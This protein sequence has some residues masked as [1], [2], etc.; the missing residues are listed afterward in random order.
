MNIKEFKG[1]TPP[2]YVDSLI[3]VFPIVLD[4]S[5][6]NND[7]S[8]GDEIEMQTN[9]DGEEV[10]TAEVE[11]E[12]EGDEGDDEMEEEPYEPLKGTVYIPSAKKNQKLNIRPQNVQQVISL[13]FSKR[14]Q[15]TEYEEMMNG[16]M[17]EE[18]YDTGYT[19]RRRSEKKARKRE[20]L[21]FEK[22]TAKLNLARNDAR[23]LE[24]ADY[25]LAN[26]GSVRVEEYSDDEE[27]EADM[28]DDLTQ[29]NKESHVVLK[30]G[31]VPNSETCNKESECSKSDND[32]NAIQPSSSD[33]VTDKPSATLPTPTS[34]AISL[35]YTFDSSSLSSFPSLLATP[36]PASSV[37][38]SFPSPFP[39]FSAA[40]P[41]GSFSFGTPN[42]N[43][44]NLPP[45]LSSEK[46]QESD[47]TE[48]TTSTIVNSDIFGNSASAPVDIG[49]IFGNSNAKLFD[50]SKIET[51]N[52]S[53]GN[54][55]LFSAE[56]TYGEEKSESKK[57]EETRDTEKVIFPI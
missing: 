1:D 38:S 45:L 29:A 31:G 41:F 21:N 33:K 55:S 51:P 39:S 57:D 18:Y 16:K 47:T 20:N 3:K 9:S 43:S 5:N 6:I 24:H 30:E 32:A 23:L 27:S 28:V 46:I 11:E 56:T 13:M 26:P 4:P 36:P 22:E 7:I 40:S 25:F 53:F 50:V 35:S 48:P 10:E 2:P 19:G 8:K 54:S 34:S 52:S 37:N 15:L 14:R 42:A 12:G 17:D 44:T 49:S